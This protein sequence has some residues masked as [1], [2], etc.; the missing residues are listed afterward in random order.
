MRLLGISALVVATAACGSS[1]DTSTVDV[2][3][4]TEPPTSVGSCEP[5]AA[6]TGNARHV[7]AYCTANG[8]QCSAYGNDSLHCSV[9]LDPRGGKRCRGVDASLV[10]RDV[11]RLRGG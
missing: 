5:N 10:E 4:A 6:A 2:G 9:D 1:N 3:S 8:G 7:G 11:A